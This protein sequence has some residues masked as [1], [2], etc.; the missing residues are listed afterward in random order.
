MKTTP[1]RTAQYAPLSIGLHWLMLCLFVAVY[2]CIEL[3]VLFAKGTDLREGLKAAHFMLGL[4]VL[5]LA[6]L[7][8][9]VRLRHLAPPIEPLPPRWQNRAAQGMHLLLYAWMLCMPLAGWLMLSAEGKPIPFFE[10]ELPALMGKDKAAAS[11]IKEWHEIAGRVGYALIALHAAVAL[12]HHFVKHDNTLL[13]M[14]PRRTGS[15]A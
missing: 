1:T 13:R 5:V 10:L 4:L 9:A 12:L 14:L 15:T 3:R 8:I 11:L 6:G 2:A 7:R